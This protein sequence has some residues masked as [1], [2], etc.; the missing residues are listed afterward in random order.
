MRRR[1]DAAA[2]FVAVLSVTALT[3]AQEPSSTGG[4]EA[5]AK[6]MF[7]AGRAAFDDGRYGDALDRWEIAF[8]LSGRPAIRYNL[9]LAHERLGQVDEAIAAFENYLK[10]DSKGARAEEVRA[11][12]QDL[13]IEQ[14]SR[15][16]GGEGAKPVQAPPAGAQPT[17]VAEPQPGP[18][19]E[20][21]PG[22]SAAT[23]HSVDGGTAWVPWVVM[24]VGTAALL[25]SVWTGSVA[26]SAADDLEAQCTGGVCPQTLR[27]TRDEAN[28]Y[29]LATD[30][31]WITGAVAVGVGVGLWLAGGGDGDTAGA[32]LELVPSGL[33]L[34]GLL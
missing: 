3:S 5:E 6:A 33:R 2:A 21:E 9:G 18:A 17:S 26:T 15:I 25:T 8:R 23:E 24:G 19:V 13:R 11:K 20:P 29:A 27:D 4:K 31:L 14:R 30:V 28:T 34:S 12:L 16:D 10:W 32:R 7:E 22:A 1:V